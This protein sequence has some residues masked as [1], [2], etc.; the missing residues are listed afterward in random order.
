MKTIHA[1]RKTSLPSTHLNSE[2]RDK[3]NGYFHIQFTQYSV[4]YMFHNLYLDVLY[5]TNVS[6]EHVHG[7]NTGTYTRIIRRIAVDISKIYKKNI[8]KP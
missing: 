6:S 1:E 2:Q 3:Y 4:V 7:T 5:A 8:S